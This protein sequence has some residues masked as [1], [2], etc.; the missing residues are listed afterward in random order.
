[1]TINRRISATA[2][3]DVDQVGID[4]AVGSTLRRLSMA[5]LLLQESHTQNSIWINSTTAARR[6]PAFAIDTADQ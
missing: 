5:S 1:M 6:L 2:T 4:R 3:R